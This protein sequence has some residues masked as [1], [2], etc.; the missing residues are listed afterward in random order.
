MQARHH[1]PFEARIAGCLAEIVALRDAHDLGPEELSLRL[2]QYAA[3]A[4]GERCPEVE[5]HPVARALVEVA[6]RLSGRRRARAAWERRV[7]AAIGAVTV[8]AA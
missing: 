4:R 1:V 3:C 6:T 7:Q 5:F 2:A 8:R